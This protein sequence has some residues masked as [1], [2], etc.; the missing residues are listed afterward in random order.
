MKQKF[1]Y[2]TSIILVLIIVISNVNCVFAED[3]KEEKNNEYVPHTVVYE[4]E[5]KK[6][7]DHYNEYKGNG[8][9]YFPMGSTAEDYFQECKKRDK[10]YFEKHKTYD[11]WLEYADKNYRTSDFKYKYFFTK[12]NALKGDY[13]TPSY[14]AMFF[15]EPLIFTKE[16]IKTSSNSKGVSF[17]MFKDTF[18]I[19]DSYDGGIMFQH[20]NSP[21]KDVADLLI[22]HK[23]ITDIFDTHFVND[24]GEKIEF[25]ES[26]EPLKLDITVTPSRFGYDMDYSL[27]DDININDAYVNIKM[28]SYEDV[29]T[30]VLVSSA[31]ENQVNGKKSYRNFDK[32]IDYQIYRY[33]EKDSPQGVIHTDGYMGNRYDYI[34]K[35]SVETNSWVKNYTIPYEKLKVEPNKIY[36]LHIFACTDKTQKANG[37]AINDNLFLYK[38]IPFSFKN[39]VPEYKKPPEGNGFNKDVDEANKD[40]FPT[41]PRPNDPAHSYLKWFFN[42][43]ESIFKGLTNGFRSIGSLTKGFFDFIG[44]FFNFLPKELLNCIYLAILIALILRIFGR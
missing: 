18:V 39:K 2:L 31:S 4:S 6:Y 21:K 16:G 43:V 22:V 9:H 10:K 27:I 24:V 17:R 28:Q 30:S 13:E 20:Q 5:F 25:E 3:K 26:F 29:Y 35:Q 36:F 37:G 32:M 34:F 8:T 42:G 7:R 11:D 41:K 12:Y 15:T 40:S 14:Y 38:S 1:K 33:C 19:A 44:Q 23:P